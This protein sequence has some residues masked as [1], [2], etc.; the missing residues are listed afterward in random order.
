MLNDLDEDLEEFMNRKII[1]ISDCKN[2]T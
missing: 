1:I 2:V